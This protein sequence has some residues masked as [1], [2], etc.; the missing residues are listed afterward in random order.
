MTVMPFCRPKWVAFSETLPAPKARCIQHVL[1]TEVNALAH[2]GFGNLGSGPDDDPLDACRGGFQV[3]IAAVTLNHVRVGIDGEYL[4]A[5]LAESL[6]DDVAPVALRGSGDSG[7]GHP[8]IRHEVR[9]SV[10]C[11]LH[12]DNFLSFS[13]FC[14]ES[15]L[16]AL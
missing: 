12:V 2:R 13:F 14:S 4:I 3:V 1:D 7:Y 11:G 5:S 6:I 10:S 16:V 8:L 9:C 15:G